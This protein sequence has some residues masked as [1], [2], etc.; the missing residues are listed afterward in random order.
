MSWLHRYICDWRYQGLGDSADALR[1]VQMLT[2]HYR[3]MPG[4]ADPSVTPPWYFVIRSHMYT[5][6]A[7]MIMQDHLRTMT[8]PSH[9]H[10]LLPL[11][12]LI[13]RSVP[14]HPLRQALLSPSCITLPIT[15][16]CGTHGT[17][18]HLPIGMC[19][20]CVVVQPL[21]WPGKGGTTLACMTHGHCCNSCLGQ[22]RIVPMYLDGGLPSSQSM[23][24]VGAVGSSCGTCT[25]GHSRAR[26]KHYVLLDVCTA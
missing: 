7:I 21:P 2:W 11:S 10:H 15:I 17:L 16:H 6:N 4:R 13:Y 8:H 12:P 25:L 23:G 19:Y 24:V 9:H 3:C 26:A 5:T 18:P 20:T 14:H 1:A 22:T